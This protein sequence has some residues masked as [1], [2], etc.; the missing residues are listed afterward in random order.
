MK[1][2]D[3]IIAE[4]MGWKIAEGEGGNDGTGGIYTKG[5]YYNDKIEHMP[6]NVILEYNSSWDW[7][8]PVVEKIS[9]FRLLYPDQCDLVCNCKIV[10][11]QKHLYEKVV[12]FIKWYNENEKA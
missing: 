6:V 10:I 4:F 11:G 7:L 5:Q 2:D 9:E 8:M 1:T 3:Q 12:E